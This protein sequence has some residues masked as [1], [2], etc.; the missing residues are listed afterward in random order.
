[1]GKSKGQP[2][3][4]PKAEIVGST[5]TH[6]LACRKMF[7][8]L[9]WSLTLCQPV[10]GR[11]PEVFFQSQNITTRSKSPK[12]AQKGDVQKRPKK[13]KDRNPRPNHLETCRYPGAPQSGRSKVPSF[14][15]CF[16]VARRSALIFF[17]GI[18]LGFSPGT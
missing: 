9:F 18:P 4:K 1:M 3:G 12:R 11:V 7:I 10:Y 5:K 8:C 17:S 2:K 16:V 13:G 14:V 6:L 15:I